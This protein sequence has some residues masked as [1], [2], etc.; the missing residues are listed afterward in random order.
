V[1]VVGEAVEGGA[2]EERLPEQL[3]LLREGAVRGEDHRALSY[4][5][6]TIS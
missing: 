1:G 5:S 2:G 4:L 6:A 3:G